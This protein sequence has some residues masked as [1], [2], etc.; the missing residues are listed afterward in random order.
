MRISVWSSDVCSSDLVV[1]LIFFLD[2]A[3][4]RDR[5]LDRRLA[6]ENGLE[7]PLERGVFLDMLAIFVERRRADAVEFAACERGFKQVRGVH[8]ALTLA[9]ADERVHPVDEQDAFALGRLHTVDRKSAVW[10]KS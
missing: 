4:D 6:D 2:A 3:Q 1:Q 9:G 8:S 10:G 7:A 5:I